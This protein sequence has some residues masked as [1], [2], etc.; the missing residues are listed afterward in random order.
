MAGDDTHNGWTNRETWCA[1]LYMDNDEGFYNDVKDMAEKL[2]FVISDVENFIKDKFEA[3][4]EMV[5]DGE[6]THTLRSMMLD[7]G[8]LYRVDFREIA[9]H[10]CEDG[11]SELDEKGE[12]T[13]RVDCYVNK[14]EKLLEEDNFLRLRGK[15][16]EIIKE[17]SD[18]V[19]LSYFTLS[20][21]DDD[22]EMLSMDWGGITVCLEPV[23]RDDDDSEVYSIAPWEGDEAKL[24]LRV[25]HHKLK[26]LMKKSLS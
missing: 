19:T 5:L 8:S 26:P 24:F 9:E 10:V 16:S 20:D 22:D 1:N 13:V 7:I 17:I 25:L 23:E 6:A 21:L 18:Y 12:V 3:L 15:T 4:S 14:Q 11:L 2:N